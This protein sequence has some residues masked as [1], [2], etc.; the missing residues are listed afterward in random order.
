[1]VSFV[2]PRREAEIPI[3]VFAAALAVVLAA[4]GFQLIGGF[5]PCRLC[6][7][8]RIPYYVVLP[9]AL[10]AWGVVVRGGPARLA[11]LLMAVA[12]LTFLAGFY[13]AVY[14]AGV[15]WAWWPDP[16]DCGPAGGPIATTDQLLSQLQ[17]IQIVSCSWVPWRF[18]GLSLAGMNAIASLT[19]ATAAFYSAL[20]RLNPVEDASQP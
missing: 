16:S 14:H 7:Q 12:G 3:L 19:L 6:L 11:R 13:L 4:W 8:Q 5:P 18:L 17:G 15:E 10:A 1:M 20:R 9:I 2:R